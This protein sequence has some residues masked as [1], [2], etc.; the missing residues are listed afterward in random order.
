MS[1]ASPL[2]RT[3]QLIAIA[4]FCI[5][6]ACSPFDADEHK[7]VLDNP[8]IIEMSKSQVMPTTTRA[9]SLARRAEA[10]EEYDRKEQAVYEDMHKLVERAAPVRAH[11]VKLFDHLREANE[12]VVLVRCFF[13]SFCWFF[14]ERLALVRPGVCASLSR[15][16]ASSCCRCSPAAARHFVLPL[17]V[18][19]SRSSPVNQSRLRR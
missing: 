9:E 16:C 17:H 7:L 19:G 5:L 10:Q 11:I 1:A 15:F 18:C 2:E 8:H 14:F 12:A 4:R 13:F 3:L 6:V